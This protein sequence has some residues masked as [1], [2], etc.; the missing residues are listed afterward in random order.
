MEY[1]TPSEQIFNEIKAAAKLVWTQ[2]SDEYGYVTE[3]YY[4]IDSI[5]NYSDNVMACYKMFDIINQTKMMS[6]LSDEAIK[7]IS[8]N[9]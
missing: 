3:R 9:Y 1:P 8:E 6:H 7:Y 4:V 2:Y 5:E